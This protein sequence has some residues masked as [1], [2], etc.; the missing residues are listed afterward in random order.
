M[1]TILPTASDNG[2]RDRPGQ[3]SP[4]VP[5]L[6]CPALPGYA[7]TPEACGG[8]A[9]R[10]PVRECSSGRPSGSAGG[11]E[12]S[13]G[14]SDQGSGGLGRRRG[15]GGTCDD[16]GRRSSRH[17]PCRDPSVPLSP[18][19]GAR[20]RR[21]PAGRAVG[22]GRWDGLPL[23]EGR[24]GARSWALG[25]RSR[26]APGEQR[27][28]SRPGLCLAR[29]GGRPCPR[30]RRL[31]ARSTRAPRPPTPRWSSVGRRRSTSRLSLPRVPPASAVTA[32][33]P[34][35]GTICFARTG[36]DASAR[37]TARTSTRACSKLACG[38]TR[39]RRLHRSLLERAASSRAGTT[40]P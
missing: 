25:A 34:V 8:S 20:E 28:T 36:P 11:S 29:R 14:R 39:L 18:G 13:P 6:P 23:A 7:N 17:R 16:A 37:D 9:G 3:P 31:A 30:R 40:G 1:A 10:G 2:S 27:R 32:G 26:A 19:S 15:K 21:H 22:R 35:R 5:R 24:P 12:S 4:S 33:S 38:V